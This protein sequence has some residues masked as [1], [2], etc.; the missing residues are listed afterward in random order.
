MAMRGCVWTL[1][2]VRTDRT[3][4]RG[5]PSGTR[6]GSAEVPQIQFIDFVVVVGCGCLLLAALDKSGA[7]ECGLLP[8]TPN[9]I[10]SGLA[11]F[12]LQ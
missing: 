2:G 8:G 12:W 7:G 1:R 5:T 6:L 10:R 11:F 4:T 9:V 3:W